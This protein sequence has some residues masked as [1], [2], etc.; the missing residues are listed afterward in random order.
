MLLTDS[1]CL[2]TLVFF[3][4]PL[5][6]SLVLLLHL[7]HITL[8]RIDILL[9]MLL[10][11][12]VQYRWNLWICAFNTRSVATLLNFGAYNE[13]Q[14][15]SSEKLVFVCSQTTALSL[16]NPFWQFPSPGR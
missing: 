1:Q 2:F 4:F 6:Q 10:L 12:F 9:F 3:S 8:H 16:S 14:D 7:T 5:R 11:K 13:R 15:D